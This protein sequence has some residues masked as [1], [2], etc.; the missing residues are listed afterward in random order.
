MT[1]RSWKQAIR[2]IALAAGVTLALGVTGLASAPAGAAT[3]TKA[4]RT[5]TVPGMGIILVDSH[6]HALYT[7]TDLLPVRVAFLA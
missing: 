3:S 4:V 5:A 7:H 1:H 2:A 6:G